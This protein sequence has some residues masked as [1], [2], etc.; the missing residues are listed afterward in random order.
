MNKHLSTLATLFALAATCGCGQSDP[1]GEAAFDPATTP[2]QAG[3]SEASGDATILGERDS[4]SGAAGEDG[5]TGRTSTDEAARLEVAP[6]A[7]AFDAKNSTFVID[8]RTV[9]LKDGVARVSAAPGSASS[10][11]T[12][13][14]GQ[15]T[16]GDLTGD[17]KA[18][19]AYIVTRDG[20]GSGRFFYA[21]AA[22]NGPDGYR[23][24]NA[25]LIGDRI[26]PQW[27]RINAKEL[28]VY[29]LGRAQ[30]EPM[31]A[32]PSRES[33]L[34]LKV[35]AEGVLRGLMQ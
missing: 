7:K 10:V 35:S 12:R 19:V 11:I 29:F 3:A 27:L 18:D 14:Y 6:N 22:I 25:F 33:V 5:A 26:E 30:G 17:G 1:G 24:T 8:G 15:A 20:A 13:Y 21:V 9:V 16:R 32:T 34:L 2:A 31:T 23:T 28:Q 4:T